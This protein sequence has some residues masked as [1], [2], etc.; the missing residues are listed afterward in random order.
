MER[1][2]LVF[3][4]CQGC[5]TDSLSVSVYGGIIYILF[6]TALN[7]PPPKNNNNNNNKKQTK[8]TQ[9]TKTH[10]Q[11]TNKQTR[12]KNKKANIFDMSYIEV[13]QKPNY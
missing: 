6:L 3:S 1:L 9:K 12:N 11:K 7:A 4:D 10:I 13:N 5:Q 8:N 2:K